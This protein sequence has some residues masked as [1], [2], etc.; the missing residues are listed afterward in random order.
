MINKKDLLNNIKNYTAEQI[1]EAVRNDIVSLYELGRYTEGAFTPLLKREVKAIL[2]RPIPEKSDFASLGPLDL[3]NAQQEPILTSNKDTLVDDTQIEQ[4]SP[5]ISIDT[6]DLSDFEE[7][8][9]MQV[10]ID[11]GVSYEKT[12]NQTPKPGMFSQSFSFKGRIRRTEYGL[13]I[14]IVSFINL[15]L[16]LIISEAEYSDSPEGLIALYFILLIP[17]LWFVWAQ[18]AK[19]CHDLGNSGFFQLIPLYGFWMLFASG[20]T[21]HNEYGHSPK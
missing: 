7:D 3:T 8:I 10:S 15:F 18:G 12:I 17:L 1:A 11:E 14:I 16:S 13:S 5:P 6:L 4:S 19:R 20:D 21:M 9:P 2:E